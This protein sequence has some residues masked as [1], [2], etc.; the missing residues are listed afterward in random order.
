VPV[1]KQGEYELWKMR[2]RQYIRMVDYNM[3]DVVLNGDT[4]PQ[5]GPDGK[6]IPI[7]SDK[8]KSTGKLDIKAHSIPM[9]GIPIEFQLDFESCETTKNLIDAVETRFGGNDAIK[10]S[11]KNLR[12]HQI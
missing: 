11:R 8:E 10:K 5:K 2:M 4:L 6:I 1:L 3:W 7:K 9:M 12:K